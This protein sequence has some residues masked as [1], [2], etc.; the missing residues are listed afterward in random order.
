MGFYILTQRTGPRPD[1]VPLGTSVKYHWA[2]DNLRI[3][4][5]WG[6]AKHSLLRCLS[7]NKLCLVLPHPRW[8]L[9]KPGIVELAI[10]VRGEFLKKIAS[11]KSVRLAKNFASLKF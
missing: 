9:K 3:P 5:G 8:V 2:S 6:I 7:K 4:P 11:L 10:V 1:P